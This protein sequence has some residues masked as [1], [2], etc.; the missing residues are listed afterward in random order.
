MQGQA[1]PASDQYALAIMIY[2]WLRGQPPFGGTAA[3]FINQHLFSPLAA[4]RARHPE[5]PPAVEQVISTALAKDPARRYRNVLTFA[6]AFAE[7]C[8]T[9]SPYSPLPAMPTE[10]SIQAGEARSVLRGSYEDAPHLPVPITP[11]I[12]RAHEPQRARTRLLRPEV[13]LLTL[14]GTPGVGKTR[15]ALALAAEVREKFARDVCFV[16]LAAISEPDL[17][18]PTI[19]DTLGLQESPELT[20]YEQLV[21]Y[22]REKQLLLMLDTFEHLLPAASWLANLLAACPPLKILVTSRAILRPQGEYEFV[23]PPLALPDLQPLPD[24]QDLSQ[25][26]AMALF[27]QRAEA[28]K[29]GFRLT[30]ENAA[31]IA[32]I[33][34]RL[35]GVP[36]VIELAAACIKLFPPPV[37]LTRLEH[38]FGV[39]SAGKQDAPSHQQTLRTIIAW[40]YEHL[41]AEEQALFRRLAVFAGVFSLEAAEAVAQ[42]PGALTIPVLDGLAALVDHSLL[43]QREE[44]PELLLYLLAFIREY[45]WECLAASGELEEALALVHKRMNT[46]E[47]VRVLCGL[48]QLA[49][50]QGDLARAR[51]LFEE[52]VM[53]SLPH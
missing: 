7:A 20:P 6:S 46:E 28:I 33:C 40:S 29:P 43:K 3:E 37:L 5:I 51:A 48:G 11:L 23:V 27:L 49:R 53:P 35:G 26:E 36:L 15:L 25:V 18:V 45:G 31:A 39:L 42:A 14:T 2:E 50:R 47:L 9:V 16:G 17:L 34:V 30:R 8:Q 1:G 24:E 41:T 32:A 13:R 38:G 21:A 44:G 19:R 4:L 10:T 52:G 22:L 12:G